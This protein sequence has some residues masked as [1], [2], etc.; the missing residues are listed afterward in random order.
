MTYQELLKKAVETISERGDQ[1]GTVENNFNRISAIASAILDR[2]VTPY[3]IAMILHAL[4][5]A[6]IG[7]SP[8][9]ADSYIDGINYLA[10]AGGFMLDQQPLATSEMTTGKDLQEEF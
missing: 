8:T 6:R 2:Q 1:Y 4:K 3:E 10:F 5:L 9:N 7:A